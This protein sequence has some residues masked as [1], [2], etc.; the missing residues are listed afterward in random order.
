LNVING[1]VA[2]NAI[3]VYINGALVADNLA[4][5]NSVDITVDTD[6]PI[7]L[8][9]C[10]STSTGVE[11]NGDCIDGF[12]IGTNNQDLDVDAGSN[13]TLLIQDS[14]QPAT[15]FSPSND[16]G[17]TGLGEFNYTLNISGFLAGQSLT[18]DVC[19]GGVKVVDG[20]SVGTSV[21]YPNLP[22]QQ[23]ADYAIFAHE[24]GPSCPSPA[25]NPSFV[26]GTNFVQT[27]AATSDPT[28]GSG[29]VSVL[30]VGQDTVPNNPDTAAFCNSILSGPASLSGFQ[31]ALQ[32]L[33]GNVDPTT[34]QT[35]HDT[36]P[37]FGD[38]Q[39][40]VETYTGVIDAGDASVTPALTDSWA[41]ATAGI[42]DI[43][44][45]FKLVDYDLSALPTDAVKSIVMGANGIELPGVPA[46]PDVV[47]AT[48]A[49]TAFVT[50]TCLA[51]PT[52]PGPT[53][54]P[55]PTPAPIVNA[56]PRFTG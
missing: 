22:A 16:L 37:S 49:I 3:D 48:D 38:M 35:I 20:Q 36:Q 12:Q 17:I 24:D 43:L 30:F 34:T 42:R 6:N 8:N 9:A 31:P 56:G 54:E 46:D 53:P 13:N 26:A 28:C 21:E 14:G 44:T 7:T 51:T 10:S 40:F 55:G 52:P 11:A 23:A 39:T 2:N 50:G 15:L 32:A 27:L 41:T 29:C 4:T 5:A 1:N 45:T 33:V 19:I 25:G 18:W 47:A